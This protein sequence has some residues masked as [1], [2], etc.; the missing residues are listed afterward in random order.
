MPNYQ[1]LYAKM[2]NA[3]TDALNALDDLNIGYAQAL[4][5]RAQQEAEDEYLSEE[6]LDAGSQTI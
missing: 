4:L 3:A 1:K 5:R 2:F 6:S